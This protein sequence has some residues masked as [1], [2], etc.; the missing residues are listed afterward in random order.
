MCKTDTRCI[1]VLL[2]LLYTKVLV[3][4]GYKLVERGIASRS[5]RVGV[6]GCLSVCLVYCHCVV[7]S[8]RPP[9]RGS[10]PPLL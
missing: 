4:G 6:F 9:Y 10:L 3:V 5:L 8:H 1:L 2:V 7:S